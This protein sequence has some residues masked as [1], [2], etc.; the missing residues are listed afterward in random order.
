MEKVFLET[1]AWVVSKSTHEISLL[2]PIDEW[3]ARG[4]DH[5]LQVTNDFDDMRINKNLN[6]FSF[7]QLCSNNQNHVLCN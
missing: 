1:I 7:E 4:F 6:N 2:V 3:G 5:T